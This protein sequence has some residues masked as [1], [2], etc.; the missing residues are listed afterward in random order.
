[1]LL[2]GL[3][4]C[5]GLRTLQYIQALRYSRLEEQLRHHPEAPALPQTEPCLCQTPQKEENSESLNTVSLAP[6]RAE[7]KL[8]LNPALLWVSQLW[9]RCCCCLLHV[10]TWGFSHSCWVGS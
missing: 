3:G 10:P 8:R 2:A 6:S 7:V 5:C 1:M 9:L 4:H